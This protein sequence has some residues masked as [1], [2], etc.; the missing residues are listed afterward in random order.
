MEVTME[1]TRRLHRLYLTAVV[2]IWI[3]AV[4]GLLWLARR[5]RHVPR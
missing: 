2:A 4:L 3:E 5:R 1:N